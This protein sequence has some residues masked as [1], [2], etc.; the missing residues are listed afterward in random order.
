MSNTQFYNLLRSNG[1]GKEDKETERTN[2]RIKPHTVLGGSFNIKND[3]Y[4]KFLQH[5]CSD[6]LKPGKI[7]Y[8]TEK[9]LESGGPF[10]IDLDFRYNY[11]VR[12]R[13]HSDDHIDEFI[14]GMVDVLK[15]MYQMD[16]ST[17]FNVYVMQ[18][19]TVNPLKEKD[20]TKDG[21]HILIGLKSDK[22]TS[23]Y[24][25]NEMLKKM[26]TIFEKL[27]LINSCD[28]IYDKGVAS[29]SNQWQLYGSQKPNHKAYKLHKI[30]ELTYDQ[31][32]DEL[33]MDEIDKD[34][35]DV[36]ENI[37][38][39]SV[40]NTKNPQ[41]FIK[42]S[43]V[44][45][46]EDFKNK[47]NGRVSRVSASH[48]G[49]IISQ[50][51]LGNEQ[52]LFKKITGPEELELLVAS[53]LENINDEN[54]ELKEYHKYV[55][56]L[57]ESYYGN[58]SYNKWISVCWAL[59]NLHERMLL[60]WIAF[61]AKSP[62]FSYN[63]IDELIERWNASENNSKGLTKRSVIFWI[64]EDNPSA[65]NEIH[66]ENISHTIEQIV[67]G[68][69]GASN[70]INDNDVSD[71][72]FAKI[73]F[74]LYKGD[75]VCASAEKNIWYKY[76]NNRWQKD[77]GAISLRSKI[78]RIKALL[79]EKLH[80][81][82]MII[83]KSATNVSVEQDKSE[84]DKSIEKIKKIQRRMLKIIQKIGNA[85][86]KKNIL[87]EAKELFY[88]AEFI[89]KL[90]SKP[91]LI[92]FNNGVIDFEAKEFR[93]GRPEDYI[94]LSTNTNYIK[95][96][97]THKD[98][99]KEIRE[100][101][102]QIYPQPELCKYMWEH[103]A[104]CMTGWNKMQ[105][106]QMYIGDGQNGKSALIQLMG[107][108]LGG[109]KYEV[110]PSIITNERAKVGGACPEILGMKGKRLVC[111]QETKKTDTLNEAIFKQ[112]T[113]GNDPV[114]AR[115]LYQAE[116]IS[117]IAQFKLV[118]ASNYLMNIEATDHG[119]W[120][121]VRVAPHVSLFTDNPVQGDREKPY[122][123]K[124]DMEIGE[125]KF[126]IWK[127][128]LASMLVEI[129]YE[130][131]GVVNDCDI[132][133]SKSREYQESQDSIA[134]FL[135]DKVAQRN[136]AHITKQDIS[137][138]FGIWYQ[139]TYG[140]GG[141]TSKDLYEYM[142][143]RFG[144]ARNSTWKDIELVRGNRRVGGDDNSDSDEESDSEESDEEVEEVGANEI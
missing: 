48:S 46:Y 83:T 120:R 4:P 88:D 63:S 117:F 72:T 143:K 9:Q 35:F 56:A 2:L 64:R 39:L 102:K 106:C 1:V 107:L 74:Q 22:T 85:S 99:V 95:L 6:I 97:D 86:V 126:P 80:E 32:D 144:R 11:D 82:N 7:E 66:K 138:E 13:L 125:K 134:E 47:V 18:K 92:A 79:H 49:G 42:S 73:L 115:G 43:F 96:D 116:Q 127:E 129:A 122:Q 108:V 20:I 38:K 33:M 59:H 5:Y 31:D 89:D 91:H 135:R 77:D 101:F 36:Y 51:V 25:R 142:N 12:T 26:E 121:R 14:Y 16:D 27:P 19:D 28:D 61:S 29:G 128:I 54:Y 112:L 15:S 87:T 124:K 111:I 17:C 131:Q 93:K 41:L 60:T 110:T 37:E 118:I 140:R 84:Q 130:T 104:S 81:F 98:I 109:Y 113:S 136:G 50:R 34:S 76:L 65:Y 94:S 24:L 8:L 30:Y 132:V 10:A 105:T 100:F 53:F 21:I 90:D 55:M 103:L 57:S 68:V 119:T 58:G 3:D 71:D 133:T 67:Y 123:F 137:T 141:P 139:Q 75:Y 23:L 114:T 52:E 40:R 44:N 70:F 69:G 62:S 45:T 78:H